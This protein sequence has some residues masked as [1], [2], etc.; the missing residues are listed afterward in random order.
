LTGQIEVDHVSFR[1]GPLDP[2]VVDDVSLKIEPGMLVAIV[3]RSGSGKS[4]LASLLLGL[5]TPSTGRVLYDGMNLSE[6]DL[7]SVR[8]QLGIVTQRTYLFGSSIGSNIAL[9]DPEIA[10]SDVVEAAKLA[11]IHGDIEQMAMRYETRL[12]DGGASLSGGQ[13]QRVALAR[14]LVR[15][16]AILL[17]DE[18]T[19]AL[20]AVTE[21]DI[22]QGIAKLHC[23]RIVIAH[24]LSTIM[25]ADRILF[26]ERGQLREVGTHA[27]LM[28]KG[29]LYAKLVEGQLDNPGDPRDPAAAMLG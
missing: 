13:R 23:T 6:L 19:S 29:G 26:M 7:Q 8:Q 15:R 5:Y 22:L 10:Q 11:Q 3:G 25:Y 9:V 17:L 2:L 16:P 27:E 28:K 18:A 20:D 4:T 21:R 12:L 1:Y 14:A 24:R